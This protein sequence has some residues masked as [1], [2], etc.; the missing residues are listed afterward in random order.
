M[1]T[2]T[3]IKEVGARWAAAELTGDTA[4][5]DEL[6][7]P[8]FRL[9]GPFGFVLDRDQWLERYRGGRLV[10]TEFSWDDVEVRDFGGVAVAIGMQNQKTTYDGHPNDGGFRVSHVF[11]REGERWRLVHVQLSLG[12]PPGPPA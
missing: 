7:A 11:V 4:V 5:L 9:I 10:N 8:E 12:S 3:E 1:S 6:A 2:E